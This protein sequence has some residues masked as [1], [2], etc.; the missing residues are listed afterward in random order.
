MAATEESVVA[1]AFA[2]LD[3][4]LRLCE[5]W[6]VITASYLV[7][8]V[9]GVKP[10]LYE[11]CPTS[12]CDIDRGLSCNTLRVQGGGAGS[13]LV[14]YY[15][16]RQRFAFE[17]L[18]AALQHELPLSGQDADAAYASDVARPIKSAG[19]TVFQ[20]S[21][22]VLA[23]LIRYLRPYRRE[24]LFGLTAAVVVTVC[25]LIPAYLAGH[26]IDDVLRPVQ[27][28]AAQPGEVAVIG[29]VCVAAIG[30]I[31]L[32]RRA[33][34]WVRLRLMALVGEFVA[35]D[36]RSELY[37]HLQ[38]LSI[39][40]YSRQRTGS[41][42]A[43]VSADT[44]RLWDFLAFGVV[45]LSL[46]VVM[47]VGL[48]GILV[49]LDP[50]LGAL[51]ALPLPLVYI[52]MRRNGRRMERLFQRGFRSW[53]H[54]MDVLSDTIPGVR[55]VR[56]FDQHAREA[57]RFRVANEAATANFNLVHTVW[58]SFWPGVMLLVESCIVLVWA[59]AL[60]RLLGREFL[61]APMSTGTFVTFLLYTGMFMGPIEVVGQMIRTVNRAKSSAHRV[62]EV[63][64]T[65]AA[66]VDFVSDVPVQRFCGSVKFEN[67]S[68]SYDDVRP[69]LK[70][71][72][73]EVRPGEMV[74]LVGASGSGK[75]TLV[76]LLMRF[77]DVSAGRIL[78]DGV[79]IR[80]YPSGAYRRQIGM[81]LQ[82]P[83][84]F[85]GSL[86]DNIR[87]GA[88]EASAQD[89]IAAARVAN[90]HDFACRLPHGYDTLVG[91][92]GHTLSGGE[93]Q[94]VSIARAV[95]TNPSLVVL[96]EATSAVDTAT[97]LK[98]QEA[99][100]RSMRGRTVIAIAHRLSTLKRA[101][102]LFVM[103][104]GSLCEAGTHVELMS[105][106]TGVYRGLYQ[107]QQSLGSD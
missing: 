14:V 46:S 101:S 95:L 28:G 18:M 37:A 62:F 29:W 82:E 12:R 91:E 10:A 50:T 48:C 9:P 24:L 63:L 71:I 100:E 13:G 79:D 83:Y 52:G 1:Y 16:H 23:R 49:S 22:V 87:Y 25:A 99:L 93:R 47:L 59:F 80:R 20:N 60:P 44:E 98:I 55:V 105:S 53:A 15:T 103:K 34:A 88:P 90:V 57:A 33:A 35:R 17:R 92:Q 67:V 41:L 21:W 43:R 56:A 58:T 65:R 39:S 4:D 64:D 26:V 11:L 30:A 69:T 106:E 36:L 8:C 84:L 78:M 86:L 74:G 76:N 104:D 89:V 72:S 45:D 54:L 5:R 96:D 38:D 51:M 7:S 61:G 102:R 107:M 97:E 3:S 42:I 19:E 31:Y 66:S 32:L 70:H 77:Y 75:T 68:F 73:L 40:F 2:D 27:L 94:R 85:H 6:L 81:V